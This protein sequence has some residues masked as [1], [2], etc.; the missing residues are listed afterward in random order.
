MGIK[1]KQGHD[2][3]KS[4][5]FKKLNEDIRRLIY[6]ELFGE[7]RLHV[8]FCHS[9]DRFRRQGHPA[10]HL[11]GWVHCVCRKN[12][13]EPPHHHD[14]SNHKWCFLSANLLRTCK[15]T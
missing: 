15:R 14:E 11:P 12:D 2:Q 8:E 6:L 10:H 1:F 3:A 13:T 7:R 9:P 4:P 5:F